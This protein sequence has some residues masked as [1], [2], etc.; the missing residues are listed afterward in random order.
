MRTHPALLLPLLTAATIA[1]GSDRA[2]AQSDNASLRAMIGQMLMVGFGGTRPQQA[3]VKT[4]RGQVAKGKVGGVFFMGRNIKSKS[5]VKKLTRYFL[6]AN[7]KM[8]PFVS[9]DQEGGRVQR[10]KSAQGFTSTQ[11]AQAIARGKDVG[12]ATRAYGRLAAQ[13]RDTGF[14]LNFAPVV[15]VDVNPRNPVIAVHKRSYGSNPKTVETYARA[16]IKAHHRSG[17]LTVLKHFPGHGSSTKDSHNGLVDISTTWKAVEL[18]PYAGLIKANSVDMV[19]VGHL[20]HRALSD[21]GTTPATLSRKA[22][23]GKLRGELNYGGVVITDDL[24]MAA[25]RKLYKK[26]DAIIRAIRAG[27]DIL[28]FS[29]TAAPTKHNFP[30]RFIQVVEAAVKRG[31]ISRKRIAQ[32]YNRIVRLKRRLKAR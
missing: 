15:D 17:V 5:Q 4:V 10:L 20:Y 29:Q 8:P 27:N 32:S 31:D 1:L 28:L 22:I 19:M 3:W 21:R 23:N 9:V 30:D 18:V 16:F 7:A 25:V 26:N 14:N 24:E 12:A 11:S 6:S 2:I 13:L